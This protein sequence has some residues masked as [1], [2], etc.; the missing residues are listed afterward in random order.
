MGKQPTCWGEGPKVYH[1]DTECSYLP[2]GT[3]IDIGGMAYDLQSSQAEM[4]EHEVMLFKRKG[5]VHM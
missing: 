4:T 1:F 5:G 2:R 3:Y